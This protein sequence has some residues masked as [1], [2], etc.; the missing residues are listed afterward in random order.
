MRIRSSRTLVYAQNAGSMV[1][2]NYLTKQVFECSSDVLGLLAEL[3]DW[4]ATEQLSSLCPGLGESE[5]ASAIDGLVGMSALVAEGSEAD[6]REREFETAWAWGVPAAMLHFCLQDNQ[7]MTLEDAEDLQRQKAQ[8]EGK[9]DLY[10]RNDGLSD[11]RRLPDPLAGNALI[12]LMARRRSIRM[13]KPEPVTLGQVSDCLFAGLGITGE[14]EN[15]VGRLPLSM[16]PSGGARNPYEA[17]VFARN[18]EGLPTGIY[19]YSAIDHTLGR[20]ADL[21]DISFAAMIGGQEWGEDVACMIVLVARLERTMWK[22]IDANAYRVVLIEA[23]HIG[24][25][26]MLA[27]T[28]HG[29][30]AC[31]T[32]A[33]NHTLISDALGLT[34]LTHAPIY[35]LSLSVPDHERAQ[36]ARR[37]SGH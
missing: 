33:L 27:A 15:C 25:N 35:A 37:Q 14:T 32:A 20:M 5:L 11:V 8:S 34:S 13:A 26:V 31:P 3:E 7:F 19:H 12:Q 18:V 4:T 6:R 29:L 36:A 28:G 2:C 16:T 21:G 10:L 9:V 23:G 24:Q 22:Y 1:A 17:Y 30:T